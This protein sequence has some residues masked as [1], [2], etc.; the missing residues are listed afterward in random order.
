[1]KGKYIIQISRN[2]VSYGLLDWRTPIK[3]L[4]G[5]VFFGIS[6]HVGKTIEEEL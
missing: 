3:L 6:I 4:F 5:I 1:M 2:S